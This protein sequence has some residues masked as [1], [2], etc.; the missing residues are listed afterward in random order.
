MLSG[1]GAPSLSGYRNPIA[2]RAQERETVPSRPRAPTLK[3]DGRSP[4]AAAP[5]PLPGVKPTGRID[6]KRPF[7]GFG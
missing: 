1:T 5:R 7:E 4:R 6:P 3:R 2:L